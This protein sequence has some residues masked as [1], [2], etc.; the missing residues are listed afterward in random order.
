MDYDHPHRERRKAFQPFSVACVALAVCGLVWLA[1]EG[2]QFALLRSKA[3]SEPA[4]V[5]GYE[6][7]GGHERLRVQAMQ[8]GR[9]GGF[10]LIDS[11]GSAPRYDKGQPVEVLTW[12]STNRFGQRVEE[13]TAYS[14]VNYWKKHLVVTAVALAAGLVGALGL[15]RR[16]Q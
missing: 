2:V 12:N 15:L 9:P 1:V 14:P 10:R 3:K 6:R 16:R 4:V 7:A 8:E 5:V 11:P 13:N